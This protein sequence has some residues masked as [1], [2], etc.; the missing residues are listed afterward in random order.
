MPER[1]DVLAV[2][3]ALRALGLGDFLTAVPALRALAAAFP[4]RTPVLAAA[5][6]LAPLAALATPGWELLDVPA[7]V[8]GAPPDP[9]LAPRLPRGALAV[10][11]HGCGPQSHALLRATEPERLL[12]F[13]TADGPAWDDGEH[14]VRRWCRL[15]AHH[16]IPADPDDLD[17]ELP[18]APPY[19][20][21][22]PTLIHPGAA[23]AARRWPTTRWAQVARAERAHGRDVLVS[24]S[25]AEAPLTRAIVASAAL[26]ASADRAGTTHDLLGLARLVS[27]AGRV[28]CGDTG[29]AHLATA[30]RIPSVVLFG[31]TDP[32]RWGPP[33]DRPWHTALWAG[34]SG[35]PHGRRAD[36]GLLAIRSADVLDALSALPAPPP[37]RREAAAPP[38]R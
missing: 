19:D 22:G 13:D 32:D 15:L 1:G 24:G 30:L 23:S 12:G 31:P 3:L 25:A 33:R 34:T 10:N 17:L 20:P 2:V 9:A 6:A 14:E 36:P 11:L 18:D 16:G 8:G 28:V 27:S 7:F 35:D 29:V 5:R 38:V 21:G 26:P 4:D 37:W